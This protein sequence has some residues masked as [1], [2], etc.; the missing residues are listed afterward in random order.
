LKNL[1]FRVEPGMKVGVVGRTGAGKS[2]ICLSISRI[3]ELCGGRIEIDGTDIRKVDLQLLRRKVTVISQDPTLFKG[4]IRFNLDP[5]RKVSDAAIERLLIKAGLED[6]LNREMDGDGQETESSH[7]GLESSQ[8]SVAAG[9]Q[10]GEL[11]LRSPSVSSKKARGVN[12]RIAENGSN[13]SAGE[14]QLICICR[15]ILRKNKVVVL[16][17][18]TANIDIVTE[19]KI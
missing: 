9:E 1:T 7:A 3:V 18:A 15:A 19:K 16:D 5:F 17:E 11:L 12:F 8:N 4:S 6:L 10:E 2:T 13:L 14:K